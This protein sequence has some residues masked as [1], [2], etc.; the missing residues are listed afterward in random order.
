[1]KSSRKIKYNFVNAK[2]KPTFKEVNKQH[3][4]LTKLNDHILQRKITESYHCPCIQQ[5]YH[6]SQASKGFRE[7]GVTLNASLREKVGYAS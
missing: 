6:V 7:L 3:V 1:M 5:V 4:H 2:Q